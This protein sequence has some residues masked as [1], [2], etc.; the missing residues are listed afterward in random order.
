MTTHE[1]EC[2]NLIRCIFARN[3]GAV[4][5]GLDADDLWHETY[6]RLVKSNRIISS[7]LDLCRLV[8]TVGTR[9]IYDKARRYALRKPLF[10]KP[11]VASTAKDLFDE[12]ADLHLTPAEAVL[13]E[14]QIQLLHDVAAVDPT[15]YAVFT[16]IGELVDANIPASVANI[17]RCLGKPY[18]KTRAAHLQ[19]QK[20]IR[21]AMAEGRLESAWL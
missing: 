11:E 10:D 18:A 19:L 3:R 17:S 4:R 6:Q 14:E 13:S 15:T 16:A 8:K 9:I 12:P 21:L 7:P 2:R 5:F 1:S 20:L